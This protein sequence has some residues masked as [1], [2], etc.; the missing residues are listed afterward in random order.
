MGPLR[1]NESL[2]ALLQVLEACAIGIVRVLW[3]IARLCVLY[4]VDRDL[5]TPDLSEKGLDTASAESAFCTSAT[6][7]AHSC[8]GG[9]LQHSLTQLRNV[10]SLIW[11]PVT[12]KDCKQGLI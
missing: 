2:L 11:K 5:P 3:R 12:F 6:T 10:S 8:V 9:D 1:V 4:L 7:Q